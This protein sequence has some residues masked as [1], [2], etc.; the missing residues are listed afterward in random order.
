MPIPYL[1]SMRRNVLK[2]PIKMA[3]IN[4]NFMELSPS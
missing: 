3:L 2:R 4:T 1:G